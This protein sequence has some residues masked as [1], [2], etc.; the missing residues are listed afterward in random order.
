L[1]GEKVAGS[2]IG[3]CGGCW[4]SSDCR[5]AS[6]QPVRRRVRTLCSAAAHSHCATLSTL[7]LLLPLQL[8]LLHTDSPSERPETDFANGSPL[9]LRFLPYQFLVLELRFL[10]QIHSNF[11]SISIIFNYTYSNQHCLIQVVIQK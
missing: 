4:Q 11:G 8:P 5:G 1:S 10:Y 2:F 7:L 9:Y 6:A 3:V